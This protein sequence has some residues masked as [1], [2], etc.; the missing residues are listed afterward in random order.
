VLLGSGL[1]IRLQWDGRCGLVRDVIAGRVGSLHDH[2]GTFLPRDM[3]G[4]EACNNSNNYYQRRVQLHSMTLSELHP[5]M[6]FSQVGILRYYMYPE[7]EFLQQGKLCHATHLSLSQK[8]LARLK[9]A[10]A[11]ITRVCSPAHSSLTVHFTFSTSLLQK[12]RPTVDE[13]ANY[14]V[15]CFI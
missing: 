14:A 4:M 3:R 7:A 11:S 12:S 13:A 8:K 5:R 10:T 1:C 9:S 6:L 15:R 2:L